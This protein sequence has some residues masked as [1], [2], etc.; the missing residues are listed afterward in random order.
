MQEQDGWTSSMD[1]SRLLPPGSL[2]DGFSCD[3]AACP[4]GPGRGRETRGWCVAPAMSTGPYHL[5]PV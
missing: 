5:S 4:W 1:H 2:V 3:Q